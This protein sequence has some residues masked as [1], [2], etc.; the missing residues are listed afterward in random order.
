[1]DNSLWIDRL[2]S[3]E[4]L[5]DNLGDEEAELLLKWG[6]SRLA[7]CNRQADAEAVIDMVREV[8]RRVG[9]GEPFASLFKRLSPP[10][11]LPDTP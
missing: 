5:T 7:G 11:E 2:Y 1:M 3:D 10:A 8:N 9:E 6:E 4:S